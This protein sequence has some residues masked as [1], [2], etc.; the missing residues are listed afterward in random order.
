VSKN[1][2]KDL[3]KILDIQYRDIEVERRKTNYQLKNVYLTLNKIIPT[4][5]LTA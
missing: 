5:N 3:D 2:E 4:T 1:G